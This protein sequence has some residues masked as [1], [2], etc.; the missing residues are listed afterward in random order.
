MLWLITP[1]GALI[2]VI[3]KK[4]WAFVR[5]HTVKCFKCGWVLKLT[6]IMKSPLCTSKSQS[7]PNNCA[8]LINQEGA[9]S[10]VGKTPV[11]P[12]LVEMAEP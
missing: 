6:G 2:K 4:G 7:C 11:G 12:T 5:P 10:V 8:D 9:T 3:L 1:S